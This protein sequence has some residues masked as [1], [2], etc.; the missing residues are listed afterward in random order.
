[1]VLGTICLTIVGKYIG[2]RWDNAFLHGL[3]I[4]MST[5]A[6]CG[7]TPM[8][9]NI[10]YYH[11]GLYELVMCIFM[12]LGTLNFGLHFVIM[13]GNIKELFKNSMIALS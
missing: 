13:H 4:F 11:S 10:L 8:S 1:M 12:I 3:W 5:W 7:F 2:L 9:Q 6:G